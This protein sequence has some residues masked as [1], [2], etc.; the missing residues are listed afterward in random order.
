MDLFRFVPGYRHLIF[1]EGK[2]P[3][4]LL[5]LAFVVAFLSARGYARAARKRGWGSGNVGGVHLHHEVVGII[6][7]LAGGIWAFAPAGVG[8]TDKELAAILFGVGAG[9]VLDE[10]ALVF[11]LRDVYWSSEG[12]DSVDAAILAVLILCLVLVSSEPFGLTAPVTVH[13]GRF[14]V[15]VVYAANVV[16][17]AITF[18]K[19]KLFLGFAA[20]AIPPFGWLGAARLAKP[21]S[22]WARWF[23]SPEKIARAQTRACSGFAARFQQALVRLV[24]GG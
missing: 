12:R 13:P 8:R 16:F 15:F 10:F 22:P 21:T 9:L 11:Y 17:T 20:I 18:L 2:E 23:Y 6:L 4:F 5:L 1:D 3:L 7:M 14:V 19:S 24:G